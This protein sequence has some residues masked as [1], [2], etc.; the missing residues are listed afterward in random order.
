MIRPQEEQQKGAALLIVLLLVASLSVVALSLTEIM[1]RSASRAAAIAQ[2]EQAHWALLGAETAALHL[3]RVQSRLK[4]DVDTLD[5]QW[6]REPITLPIENGL[7]TA[8]FR[9]RSN[10]FNINDLVSDSGA[11]RLETDAAA[12]SHLAAI[13]A[14]LG[15]DQ[16]TGEALGSSAADF[17]DQ[18]DR[19]GAGGAED[20]TYNRGEVPYRTANTLLSDVSE[21]RALRGWS[22][23]FYAALRPL[24]CVR[25]D[26]DEFGVMN[27]NTVSLAEAPV[28]R[29]ALNNKVPLSELEQIIENRPSQGFDSLETFLL[30]PTF[31]QLDPP[32]SPEEAG[33]LG[34]A[35]TLIEFNA[36]VRYDAQ[37]FEMTSMIQYEGTQQYNVV[38]RRM[39]ARN[40]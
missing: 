30:L 21:L 36:Q 28:L 4:V 5:E 1:T 3:L 32:L 17:M 12:I 6:L 31:E 26:N 23:P 39:G 9:D 40:L 10:C 24:L 37:I 2:R 11:G 7:I 33:R 15:G 22:R 18:D 38:S 27:I 13:V 35:A 29:A 8:Q 20:F 16:N 25:P 14:E 19:I 34:T